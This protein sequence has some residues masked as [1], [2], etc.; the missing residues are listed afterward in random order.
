LNETHEKCPNQWMTN[1]GVLNVLCC[2]V[3]YLDFFF[4]T[5]LTIVTCNNNNNNN[6]NNNIAFF[7]S[8]LG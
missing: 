8:K 1:K 5:A 6:N 7:P 3:R 2:V 4:G